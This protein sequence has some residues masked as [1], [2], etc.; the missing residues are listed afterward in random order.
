[1]IDKIENLSVV[2]GT[3]IG[4]SQIQSILGII[5]LSFQI[6]LIVMKFVKKIYKRIKCKDFE[7]IDKDLEETIN[8]LTNLKNE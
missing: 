7:D 8:D 1:M 2:I 3:A 6:L 5:I 4:I